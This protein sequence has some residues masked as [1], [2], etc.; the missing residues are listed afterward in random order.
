MSRFAISR[1]RTE[2]AKSAD[3]PPDLDEAKME[4][5]MED[6]AREGEGLDEEDP[7][8]MARLMRKLHESGGLPLNEG[9]KEAIRRMEAG[10]DPD[11]I[12]AELGD[13]LGEEGEGGEGGSRP[14]A[15]DDGLYPL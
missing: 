12:E 7:R 1:G 14:P 10:E 5:A 8:Q 11:K 2:D 15:Y 4:A 6:L 13:V 9:M 3:E